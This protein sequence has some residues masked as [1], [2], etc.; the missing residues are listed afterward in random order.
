MSL[1]R[2]KKFLLYYSDK[3]GCIISMNFEL[4]DIVNL[5]DEVVGKEERSVVHTQG[6]YHR[7]IHVFAQSDKSG[8]ILQ[9][10]SAWKDL[11]PLLWTSSCS[12]HLDTGEGYL[13][14][15]IRE[16]QEEMGAIIDQGQLIELLRLS[17]CSETG[18]E[19]V[20]IYALKGPI[21]PHCSTGEVVKFKSYSLEQ[22]TREIQLGAD[23]FSGSFLHIFNLIKGKLQRIT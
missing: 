16:I 8:W 14:A 7:A 9:Q 13:S 22:I 10:R 19:F 12:G 23:Q 21:F 1:N 18:N 20:R 17:P 3:N 15:A 11:D 2:A 4:F 6:L 5:N